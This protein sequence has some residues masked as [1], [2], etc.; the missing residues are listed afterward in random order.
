MAVIGIDL[1]TTNSL[2]TTWRD[3]RC[4]FIPNSFGDYLTPS[5]VS[6]DENDDI[7]VG[8][9]AKERKITKPDVTASSFKQFMGSSKVF[10]LG[11]KVFRPEELSSLIIRQLKQDA[12]VYL[13]EPV[14]EAI[15]SVPAYFNNNQRSATKLA[16][17]Y[18]GVITDRI[19]NEP[20]A[21]A[22]AYQQGSSVNGS[23]LVFDFGGGTLDV[24]IVD[25]FDN[26]VDIVAVSGDNHLGGD[27]IDNAIL[28]TFFEKHEGLEAAL[29]LKERASVCKLAEQC[30]IALSSNEKVMMTYTH[31]NKHY[32]MYL[33]NSILLDICAPIFVKIQDALKRALHD[34]G[35]HIREIDDIFLVGGTSRA[36]LIKKYLEHLTSKVPRM[37]VDPD[38]AVATGVG[39]ISGIKNRDED[40]RDTVMT[41]ICPFSLGIEINNPDMGVFD[42]FSPIIE[43]NSYLPISRKR[44]YYTISDYQDHILAKVYQGESIIASN[45]LLLGEYRIEV[46]KLKKGEASIDVE[47]AYDINGILLVGITSNQTGNSITDV[48]ITNSWLTEAEIARRREELGKLTLSSREDSQ[49]V[50][51]IEWAQRLYEENLDIKRE[52]IQERLIHFISL[53]ENGKNLAQEKK[54]IQEFEQFLK[55]MDY[56]DCG[57]NE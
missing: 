4:V 33:D 48:I 35:K 57:L 12:E 29:S 50:L 26:I 41:D 17:E 6:I 51:L 37:D 18:A 45:N 40:I 32:E 44:T 27:D 42:Q 7:L 28:Q 24:S 56:F 3:G 43:R 30:K 8:K 39:I 54:A 52:M 22:I 19:I 38:L 47:F 55:S 14:T 53:I 5:V 31:G 16:G 1:G 23:Y 21:A 15:I 13:G 49:V 46:P 10:K 25:I 2:C 20:S 34:S 9:T 36:P 11:D